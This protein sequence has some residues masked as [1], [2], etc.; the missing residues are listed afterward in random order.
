MTRMATGSDTPKRKAPAVGGGKRRTK[1]YDTTGSQSI[2]ELCP[3]SSYAK[4]YALIPPGSRVLDL[5]CGSGELALY[6]AARGDQVWAVDMNPAAVAQAAASCVETRVADLEETA[7]ASLFPGVRFDVVVF[8]D[9]LEHVRE[10]WNVLQSARAVLDTGGR[11]VASIPNFGHAAVQLAVVSGALPYRGLGILDGTHVRFF[12]LDSVTS[13]FEESGFRLQAIE[14]TTLPFDQPSDL[15]P[16]VRVLRVPEH[17][18]RHV[19]EDPENETLQFVVRAVMLPGE[20]DMDALRDRLHDV[21]AHASEQA[22]GIRNL[23]RDY[24]RALALG[25][26]RAAQVSALEGALQT[27][28]GDLRANLLA[29]VTGRDEAVLAAMAER[30]EAVVMRSQEAAARC[31]R[32][33]ELADA[34]KALNEAIEQRDDARAAG[35]EARAQVQ[36]REAELRHELQGA[37]REVAEL[38]D[39]FEAARERA[40][41]LADNH[42]RLK[43]AA[44]EAGQRAAALAVECDRRGEREAH[45][46]TVIAAADVDRAAI[47]RALADAR[48]ERVTATAQR[49]ERAAAARDAEEALARYRTEATAAQDALRDMLRATANELEQLKKRDRYEALAWIAREHEAHGPQEDG[50]QFWCK[51]SGYAMTSNENAS[52]TTGSTP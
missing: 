9:V 28:A 35:A 38:R 5:G 31:A 37:Q 34:Q 41:V 25:D 1:R 26:E 11:V 16:D 20:W 23:Q 18:E 43:A 24:A 42:A 40:R 21:E 49:D 2:E 14:R 29:A 13:L 52:K 33:V 8:A 39:A 50:A 15:V 48:R 47:E 51:R 45:A 44:V 10:P 30:D 4:L 17:I 19:R 27:A 46:A 3:N 6:L 7:I 12:T 36:I 22:I 32:E